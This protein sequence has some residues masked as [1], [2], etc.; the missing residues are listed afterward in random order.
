MSRVYRYATIGLMWI[1]AMT[2]HWFGTVFFAPGTEVYLLADPG[3]G[4]FVE[5]GWRETQYKVFAQYIPLLF[6]GFS[7]LWGFATEYE[8]AVNTGVRR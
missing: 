8:D 7:L 4:T 6:I 1:L 5:A 3:V 2:I